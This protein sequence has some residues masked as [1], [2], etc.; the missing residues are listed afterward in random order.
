[1]L[2]EAQERAE[3][4]GKSDKSSAPPMS[5]WSAEVEAITTLTDKVSNLLYVTRVA[6]GDKQVQQPK[7][8]PR[9]TTALPKIRHQKRQEQHEKLAA[10]LLGR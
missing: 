10:R 8:M 5:G 2:V 4:E 9:P 6:N 3:R 7:P 1:M